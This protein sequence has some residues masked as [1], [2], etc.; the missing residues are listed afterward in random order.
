MGWA[1][2]FDEPISLP[3]GKPLFTFCGA[4][5]FITKLPKAE[6]AAENGKPSWK[7]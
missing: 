1:R 5:L 7:R 3:E 4:A 2:K 6:H